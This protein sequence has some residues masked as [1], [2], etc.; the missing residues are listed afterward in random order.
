MAPGNPAYGA[1]R[2]VEDRKPDY[3]AAIITREQRNSVESYARARGIAFECQETPAGFRVLL[4][5]AGEVFWDYCEALAY[6][7]RGGPAEPQPVPLR[8]ARAFWSEISEEG[9][10]VIC[11]RLPG[12]DPKR[13]W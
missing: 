10:W 11:R 12:R 4:G 1:F 5:D 7:A 13:K 3:T 9:D 6:L 2:M 8:D